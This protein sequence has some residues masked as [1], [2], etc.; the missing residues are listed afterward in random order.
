MRRAVSFIRECDFSTPD[1]GL[2]LHL[3]L[4]GADPGEFR[5]EGNVRLADAVISNI[6]FRRFRGRFDCTRAGV[7]LK[8]LSLLLSRD[9]YLEG[10]AAFGFSTRLLQGEIS[11]RLTPSTVLYVLRLDP[12]RWPSLVAADIPVAFTAKLAPSPLEPSA[13]TITGTARSHY[14]KVRDLLFED[15]RLNYVCEKGICRLT[16]IEATPSGAEKDEYLRGELRLDFVRKRIRGKWDCALRLPGRLGRLDPGLGR[17]LRNV[18]TGEAPL[19]LSGELADSPWSWRQWRS[20]GQ[21]SVPELIIGE[22]YCRDI[23]GTLELSGG[24]FALRGLRWHWPDTPKDFAAL[25]VSLT[26]GASDNGETPGIVE[27]GLRAKTPRPRSDA[28]AAREWRDGVNLHGKIRLRSGPRLVGTVSGALYPAA[29]G[30][31]R[32]TFRLPRIAFVDNLSCD[33]A[34]VDVKLEISEFFLHA[35]EWKISGTLSGHDLHY[36]S[37]ALASAQT[38][39]SCTPESLVFNGIRARTGS[40]VGLALDLSIHFEPLKIEIRKG[41]I[42]GD[43]RAIRPF[44]EPQSAREIYSRIWENISWSSKTPPQVRLPSLIYRS[45]GADWRLTIKASLEA[46]NMTYKGL[47]IE[48]LALD[49]GLNLPDE[50]RIENVRLRTVNGLSQG[51]ARISFSG[52]PQCEFSF[53]NSEGR[54]D[55]KQLIRVVSEKWDP[56]LEDVTFAPSTKIS[57]HGTFFLKGA[58]VVRIQGILEAPF[59]SYKGVRFEALETKW[60]ITPGAV[61]W[62]VVKGRLFGGEFRSTGTYDVVNRIGQ[63]ALNCKRM[64]FPAVLKQFDTTGK[65]PPDLPGFLGL[66]GRL[67]FLHGWAGKNLL[68]TGTGR[69]SITDSDLWNLGMLKGLGTLLNAR[70]LHRLSLGRLSTLGKISRVEADLSFQGNRLL[71]PSLRTN[72]TILSLRGDGEYS[73][74]SNRIFFRVTGQTLHQVRILSFALR[75]LSWVFKAELTGTP[76]KHRWRMVNVFKQV[77]SGGDSGL[78]SLDGKTP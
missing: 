22:L 7:E 5:L 19:H 73:W 66:D 23:S 36:G 33:R 13:W 61:S 34:P 9:E 28:G 71:I 64:A 35:R 15:T 12:A 70:L 3:D 50:I 58:P 1:A 53:A 75:P 57:C 4:D 47:D 30:I 59:V 62:D 76:Q 60:R 72:G 49:V 65:T 54:A 38:A 2:N 14:F 31:L 20:N 77:L 74:E 43:P 6:V 46:E 26:P 44:V 63:V 8:D 39:F 78:P 10:K 68:L 24:R 17:I 67:Q 25:D 45:A 16:H 41:R 32:E 52:T 51:A 48:K 11:G 56:Y 29:Y 27:F 69:L 37:L 18:R 55:P 40:G 21:V 42:D